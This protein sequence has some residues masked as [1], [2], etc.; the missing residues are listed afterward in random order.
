MVSLCAGVVILAL[1]LR[2]AGVIVKCF[3]YIFSRRTGVF[4]RPGMVGRSH[5]LLWLEV[6]ALGLVVLDKGAANELVS[7]HVRVD[8]D[9]EDWISLVV[10]EVSEFLLHVVCP[11]V[12]WMFSLL[13]VYSAVYYMSSATLALSSS[14]IRQRRVTTLPAKFATA[15][16]TT[17]FLTA[18]ASPHRFSTA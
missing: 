9:Q 7:H 18:T 2:C 3:L 14:A 11:F 16:S 8:R 5:Q 17:C 13:L 12:V 10:Y 1:M 6:Q 15:C 4:L